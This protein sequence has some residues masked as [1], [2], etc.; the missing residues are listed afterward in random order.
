MI[1]LLAFLNY[2]TKVW[3]I[4]VNVKGIRQEVLQSIFQQCPVQIRVFL[5]RYVHVECS[6]IEGHWSSLNLRRVPSQSLSIQVP[7]PFSRS[8]SNILSSSGEY[9]SPDESEPSKPKKLPES[10]VAFGWFFR[11]K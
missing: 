6:A 2:C 11:R 10:P 1:N 4:F 7:I 3:Y 5:H 8:D 9:S